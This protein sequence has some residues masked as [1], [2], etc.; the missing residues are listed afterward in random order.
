[1]TL[2]VA[3][4][5]ANGI[6]LAADSR[7]TFG[8]P[9]GLTAVNDTVN[10]LFKPAAG[11]AVAMAGQAETGN[12]L[13]QQI[14]S[15]LAAKQNSNV[16]QVADAMRTVGTQLFT[17]WFGPPNWMIS[18]NGPIPSPRPDVTYLLA[19]YCQDGKA[20]II[21]MT[22]SLPFNFAPNL[23]TTGFAVIGIVPL[24][25]YLLNRLYRRG[26]DLDIAKDLAAYC[27]LETA[28]QDGKVGGPIRMGIVR[29]A[30]ET[31]IAT[32]AEIAELGRR[33]DAHREAL[34]NSFLTLAKEAGQPAA[35]QLAPA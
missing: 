32:D 25:V 24:A 28:S 30:T 12:S 10:K 18:G 15:S 8:D 1:M 26:L 27:I 17:Q 11:V 3:I 31:E 5:S 14:A 2:A 34:K 6:V 20:K 22:S 33:V 4:E 7:A 29:S 13:M 19:G 21:S 35:P 23:S 9:R 16:D